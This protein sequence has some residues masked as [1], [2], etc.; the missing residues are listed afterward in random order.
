MTSSTLAS[1][2]QAC[3]AT[4]VLQCIPRL[5]RSQGYLKE[6]FHHIR[7]PCKVREMAG[8]GPPCSCRCA[9]WSLGCPAA[10][11]ACGPQRLAPRWPWP[12]RCP[13]CAAAPTPR[14]SAQ[15][16]ARPPVKPLFKYKNHIGCRRI[17]FSV[18]ERRLQARGILGSGNP[19]KRPTVQ[20]PEDMDF[21]FKNLRI[22]FVL[23]A[24]AS[25]SS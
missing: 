16:T 10:R 14:P 17:V 13:R 20:P 4:S 19:F 18:E 1:R 5:C 7:N 25:L 24:I 11:A 3:P 23:E 22:K 9:L 8:I 21:S 6:T 2:S 12:H 15:P